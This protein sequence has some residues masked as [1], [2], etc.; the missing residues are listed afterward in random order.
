M[1]LSLSNGSFFS[2][3]LKFVVVVVY[4]EKWKKARGVGKIMWITCGKNMGI[5]R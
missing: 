1:T 5:K 2:L 4:R 3:V